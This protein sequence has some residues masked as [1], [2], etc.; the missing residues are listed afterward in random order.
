MVYGCAKSKKTIKEEIEAYLETGEYNGVLYIS[1]DGE[2]IIDSSYS[3]EAVNLPQVRKHSKIPLASL[4]KLFTKVVMFKLVDE[5]LIN[6]EAPI[7]SYLG[8]VNSEWSGKITV[9]HLLS[10]SAGFPREI[11]E[12]EDLQSV[13]YIDGFGNGFSNQLANVEL[14][15][16]PGANTAYSNVDYWLLG[17]IVEKVTGKSVDEAFRQILFEDAH[18][19]NSGLF[20]E[21]EDILQGYN[22]SDLGWI[23]FEYNIA[24]RY[25]SGGF[26]SSLT[27]LQKL[28]SLV[29]HTGYLSESL[30]E[31]LFGEDYSLEFYGAL[32]G[33][34]NM[35]IG[36]KKNDITIIALNNIGFPDLNRMAEIKQLVYASKNIN[37]EDSGARNK[38]KVEP[39]SALSDSVFIERK[40]AEWIGQV[41]NGDQSRIFTVLEEAAI[42]GSFNWSDPTWEE[43]AQLGDDLENFRVAGFRYLEDELPNGIEVWFVTDT[44]AKIGF[45]WIPSRADSTRIENFMVKPV[46]MKWMGNRY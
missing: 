5:G 7:S 32:P 1:I 15:Y 28:D 34:T 26:Y 10:M 25:T 43:I 44:E 6:L 42:P 3:F 24:G 39:I 41:L 31:K 37:T 35:F 23:P 13:E 36:D 46:D 27:D 8:E 17:A 18:M 11:S 4:T 2:V 14:L 30:R 20:N 40:L 33:F 9:E 29:Y 45:L 22:W 12:S 38:I 21:Q 19:T 16:E